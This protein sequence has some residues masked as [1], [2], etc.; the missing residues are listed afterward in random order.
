[1]HA[2]GR[3]FERSGLRD[4]SALVR[5]LSVLA[6]T[7]ESA[8]RVQTRDGFWLGAVVEALNDHDGK[9]VKLR[10]VWTRLAA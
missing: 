1:L 8:E 10:N 7:D 4:H 5:D 3:W 6:E 9:G 2:L